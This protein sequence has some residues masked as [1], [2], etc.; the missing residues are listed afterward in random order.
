M[1][2]RRRRRRQGR[3]GTPS[4]RHPRARAHLRRPVARATIRRGPAGRRRAPRESGRAPDTTR[5]LGTESETPPPP[6][7]KRQR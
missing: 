5:R 7:V 6:R 2:P 1:M 4:A 3:A